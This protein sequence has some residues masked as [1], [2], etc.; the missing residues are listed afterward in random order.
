[1]LPKRL[2]PQRSGIERGPLRKYRNPSG[3]MIPTWEQQLEPHPDGGS[4]ICP[5]CGETFIRRRHHVPSVWS[6]TRH[7]SKKCGHAQRAELTR[8]R[9]ESLFIPEPNS[10]CWLWI[11]SAHSET[12]RKRA[13]RAVIWVDGKHIK[14]SRVAWILYRGAEPGDFEVCHHCDNG[15]CVNPDHL[16]LGSH[17]DNMSDMARKKRGS[18]LRGE[19]CAHA[20]LTDE[21]V[22]AIFND[23][24]RYSDIA[25]S[26]GVSRSTV[27]AI[28]AGQ[29]WKH[30]NLPRKSR[31][32]SD[33]VVPQVAVREI[34]SGSNARE[35]AEKFNINVST[36][37]KI[38]RKAASHAS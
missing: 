24:R 35:I 14:A 13:L 8:D 20:V 30:L 11:G 33:I 6:K 7:C 37:Y 28:K 25:A 21:Q 9:F 3:R 10:G 31:P 26:Y 18:K 23:A 19:E 32:R 12:K 16:F 15:L 38:R 5:K 34:L 36:V 22:I 1:M 17:K 2:Q 27:C 29:N 4:K